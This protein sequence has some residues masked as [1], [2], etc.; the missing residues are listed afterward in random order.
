[1]TECSKAAPSDKTFDTNI[2]MPQRY[3]DSITRREM[4]DG[5]TFCEK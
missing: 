2:A 3:L 5:H 4:Y 1:M